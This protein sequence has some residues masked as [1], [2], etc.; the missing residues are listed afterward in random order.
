MIEIGHILLIFHFEENREDKIFYD[1]EKYRID[2]SP[3]M[4][5]EAT[6]IYTIDIKE[7]EKILK[8]HYHEASYKI[9]SFVLNKDIYYEELKRL[10]EKEKLKKLELEK[11][12]SRKEAEKQQK[13]IEEQ[14]KQIQKEIKKNENNKTV[15]YTF[16]I[17]DILKCIALY[18]IILTYYKIP[19]PIF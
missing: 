1:G 13:V 16:I 7:Y 12:K 6:S 5:K 8:M 3:Y 15:F 9:A 18:F 4:W 19:F 14:A 17:I 11:E 2:L 10:Q